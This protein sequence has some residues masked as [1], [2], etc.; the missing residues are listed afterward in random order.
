MALLSLS[1]RISPATTKAA[2]L[3]ILIPF[4]KSRI[5]GSAIVYATTQQDAADVVTMLKGEG[6]GSRCYHAGVAVADRKV[7][8]DWFVK[9]P[10]CVVV[11]TIA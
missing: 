1:L 10:D 5:G 4:L 3:A 8:Q 11:A 9:G 7:I 2:K 6:I